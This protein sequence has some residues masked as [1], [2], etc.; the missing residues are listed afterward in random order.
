MPKH[1]DDIL[2]QMSMTMTSSKP[3]VLYTSVFFRKILGGEKKR[4]KTRKKRTSDL[5]MIL[6]KAAAHFS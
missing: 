1:G 4:Q 2:F 5:I 3:I 6:M